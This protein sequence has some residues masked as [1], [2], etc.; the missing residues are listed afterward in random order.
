[1]NRSSIFNKKIDFINSHGSYLVDK[2][3][4]KK[5]LDFFGQYS[6]LA[7]G[8]NHPV[9]KTQNY[10]NEVQSLGHQKITNC[11]ILST[12]S[13]EFDHIFR[14]YTSRDIFSHYHSIMEY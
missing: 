7:I 13:A 5:Y 12:E 6:T 14:T 11:E 10:L 8:Y 1:M 9:F 4:Q 3:S 2:D